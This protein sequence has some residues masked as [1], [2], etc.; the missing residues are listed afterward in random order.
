SPRD[1]LVGDGP[2]GVGVD[3][4]V[5]VELVEPAEHAAEDVL[6]HVSGLFPVGAQQVGVPEQAGL[7]GRDPGVERRTCAH[8]PPQRSGRRFR[9]TGRQPS[10]QDIAPGR[11]T[12]AVKVHTTTTASTQSEAVSGTGRWIVRGPARSPRDS[13]AR[14]ICS[15]ARMEPTSNA[16]APCPTSFAP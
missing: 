4:A 9:C 16:Y 1:H 10:N 15:E 6:D 3:P 5:A 13:S 11:A 8:A 7:R 12:R 2:G 14:A